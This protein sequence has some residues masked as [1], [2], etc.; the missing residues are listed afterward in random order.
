MNMRVIAMYLPQYHRIPENDKWWGE[1][2]TEWTAVKSAKPLFEG[3]IQPKVPLNNYYY[4]LSDKSVMRWQSELMKRYGIDGLCFY[5]YWFKEGKRIL[6]KPAE[7][8]LKWKDIDLPFCFCWAN[9]TWARSWSSIK[10]KNAWANTFE[11]NE[12]DDSSGILLEQDYG[13]EE[14]WTVH[15]NY[16]LPFFRDNRYVMIENKPVIVLYRTNII[17]C[18]SEMIALWRKLARENGF[19]DLYVIGGNC[20]REMSHVLDGQ[21]YHEPQN[22]IREYSMLHQW[23]GD[24]RTLPY[25]SIWEKILSTHHEFKICPYYEGFVNYDD[26]PRRGK[27]GTIITGGTPSKF[28]EYLA[29]L[30]LKNEKANAGITFINAWNEWGE[31]MYLEPDTIHQYEWLKTIDDARKM[32]KDNSFDD[33]IYKDINSQADLLTKK[34]DL[35]LHILDKWLYIYEYGFKLTDYIMNMYPDGIAIYGY[36]VL[37]AHLYKELVDSGV[38]VHFVIEKE[39]DKVHINNNVYSPD[40]DYPTTN[41][42]LIVTAAFDYAVILKKM[43]DKGFLGIVSLEDIINKY[44]IDIEHQYC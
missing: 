16:L 15:F 19:P 38:K 42:A 37:G 1:G 40:M 9:E 8:L 23:D 2:F 30:F 18:L 39:A 12:E 25:E 35:N 17:P 24:I 43:S 36:G 10:T 29:R 33:I 41:I 27:E 44:Y 5:H 31:G 11:N 13:R 7:N 21:L 28:K 26:T 6:E 14:D 22:S 34:I 4:D 3:H 20:E 32:S